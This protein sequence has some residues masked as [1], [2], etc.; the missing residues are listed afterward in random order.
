MCLTCVSGK[1]KKKKGSV[2]LKPQRVQQE[3]PEA[4]LPV[5]AAAAAAASAG[6]LA[7]I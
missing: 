3:Q 4:D 6:Q 1:K 7:S 5:K 2:W